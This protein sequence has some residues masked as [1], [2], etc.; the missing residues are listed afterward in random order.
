MSSAV[1]Q[2][3][4]GRH[5][6]HHELGGAR[7]RPPVGLA[8]QRVDVG[9]HLTD[10]STQVG[11]RPRRGRR[12]P[13][14]RAGRRAAPWRRPPPTGRRPAAP[15]G[16]AGG[17]R[18]AWR[19]VHLLLEVAVL[20]HPG[21]LDR[22]P[23]VQLAPLPADVRLAQRRRQGAGL[24]P[25]QVGAV[26]HVVDLLAQLALPRRAL[27][28]D[29]HQ[30]LVEPVEPVAQHGLVLAACGQR[31]QHVG[32][33]GAS[34]PGQHRDRAEQHADHEGQEGKCDVH[35]G[36]GG[37]GDRHNRGARLSGDRLGI[38][39]RRAGK[40]TAVSGVQDAQ[41]V[42]NF[43]IR[44]V[45][46]IGRYGY[47]LHKRSTKVG[48][49]PDDSH[50]ME[51]SCWPDPPVTTTFDPPAGR[52]A[53]G[54]DWDRVERLYSFVRA[55]AFER[56][57][58][59][60]RSG[61]VAARRQHRQSILAIDAMYSQAQNGHPVVASCAITFFRG[62]AMRDARHPSS[63]VSGS[64][65]RPGSPA[66]QAVPE[67]AGRAEG[68][69]HALCEGERSSHSRDGVGRQARPAGSQRSGDCD[70][71][72]FPTPGRVSVSETGSLY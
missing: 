62:R 14:R 69:G 6:H 47:S 29:V 59:A 46:V 42:V 21:Q 19:Q 57:H 71:R 63:S 56:L 11:G 17:G 28:L 34:R 22:A 13:A 33:A 5:E 36:E 31:P 3:R 64:A 67:R 23:Q 8:R 26:P 7:Q 18:P 2:E 30:P 43:P 25:Q 16:R 27:L 32:V 61:D 44:A 50:V 55:R 58:E 10:V 15:P 37:R 12:S 52:G 68:R 66:R 45:P 39:R 70:P 24:A 41:F 65:R 40:W 51:R 1:G 72:R 35:A 4:L 9:A 53:S 20:D 60:E 48:R 49:G 38:A 54:L